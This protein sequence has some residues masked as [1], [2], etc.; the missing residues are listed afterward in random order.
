MTKQD[1]GFFNV[2][3]NCFDMV[4]EDGDLKADNGMETACLI[5]AFTDKRVTLEQ[6]P[7][8][9][10]DRRGWW[11]DLISEIESDKIGSELWRLEATGKV[12]TATAVELESILTDAFAWMIEDGLSNKIDIS[13][14]R[15]GANEITATVDIFRPDGD[16][17]PL[18]F[19]WDGQELKLFEGQ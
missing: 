3:G 17:I 7:A 6:L 8:S 2:G 13:A 10:K 16:N 15:T 4:L 1:V 11:A 5:S 14:V 19:I 12:T 9:H 18:K